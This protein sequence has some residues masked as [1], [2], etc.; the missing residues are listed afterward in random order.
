MKYTEH[1]INKYVTKLMEVVYTPEELRD[2]YIIEGESSSKRT[3]ID[4]ERYELIKSKYSYLFLFS[5]F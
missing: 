4:L 3:S 2:G 1:Q 5:N